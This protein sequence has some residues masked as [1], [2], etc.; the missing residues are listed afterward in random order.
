MT[1]SGIIDPY[2]G[3]V[4]L[5]ALFST[6]K[7]V[8]TTIGYGDLTPT[9]ISGQLFTCIFGIS[10]VASLGLVLGTIGNNLIEGRIKKI[11]AEENSFQHSILHLFE[12]GE[13][14]KDFNASAVRSLA[15]QSES[16]SWP[17]SSSAFL[18]ALMLLLGSFSL[19][20]GEG[21]DWF[22][23]I[24]FVV[25]T[26]TTIGYGDY[27]P[28]HFGTRLFSV[29]FIPISVGCV[30]H[31][32]AAFSNHIIEKR[33]Q[34]F[35]ETLFSAPLTVGYLS[36]VSSTG[37]GVVTKLDY[38]EFMLRAMEEVD[39]SLL[40][41][42]HRQFEALDVS[43]EGVLSVKDLKIMADVNLKKVQKKLELAKYKSELLSA[44]SHSS[45]SR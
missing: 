3:C 1:S 42:L 37:D 28:S 32:L 39:E 19:A 26:T 10:G 17:I 30:G 40:D 41:K 13:D 2:I 15:T 33:Q 24:Y 9:T 21:W 27:A 12:K 35:E 5:S 6:S 34:G 7:H 8:S 36:D 14:T 43:R 31:M 29:I 20:I 16:T 11:K 23:C 4:I 25:I 44:A 45:D 18:L 38:I 22:D